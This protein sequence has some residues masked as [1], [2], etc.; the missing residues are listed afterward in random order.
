MRSWTVRF[1]ALLALVFAAPVWAE[2]AVESAPAP[3]AAAEAA[4]APE[5]AAEAA[6][7]PGAPARGP[8]ALG[9]VG[10]DEEGRQGRIHTVATGDTL[11]DVSD[12]YLGTPWVWP[13]IWRDNS[14]I[15]DPHLIHPGD[16]LWIS[17]HEMRRITDAEAAA[18][19]AGG[20]PA[21]LADGMERAGGP[22]EYRFST[23]QTAGFV[24]RGTYDGN[25]TIVDSVV[26]RVYFGDHDAVIIGLG[27]GETAVGD[28]YEIFR[29]TSSVKD[30]ETGLQIGWATTV[31]GWLEVQEVH[32]ETATGMIRMS[33][34]EIRRGDHIL[35]R[36]FV[37]TDI[38]VAARPEVEGSVVHTPDYRLDMG[39]TDVVY[40]NRGAA[41]GLE[42]GSP[43]EVFRRI[44]KET[45]DVQRKNKQLPD[46]VIG[47]LIVVSTTPDTATAVITKTSTEIQRGD[48]FRGADSLW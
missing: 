21:A 44:G 40:L 4:P 8:V 10:H 25:A 14:D 5:A 12:A 38:D 15:Q 46:W 18:L 28:Q 27:E 11:W 31:L 22:E 29:K 16:K 32:E 20:S 47:K 37:N 3:E 2:D 35:P 41:D 33:R 13:S 39:S 30:P 7:A 9:P 43:L 48:S 6:P 1:C 19:L 42:V 23:I 24:T 45:D 34:G 36:P 26:D 17:P